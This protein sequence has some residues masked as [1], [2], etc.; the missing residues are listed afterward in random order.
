MCIYTQEADEVLL[1][2]RS[3]AGAIGCDVR[4]AADCKEE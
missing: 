3:A 2:A 4:F 1:K